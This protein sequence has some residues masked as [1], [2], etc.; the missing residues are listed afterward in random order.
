M[1]EYKAKKGTK[2]QTRK[3]THQKPLSPAIKRLL[4]E[5]FVLRWKSKTRIAV[6]DPLNFDMPSRQKD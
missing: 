6:Q 2:M 3:P 1:N 5:S 4:K